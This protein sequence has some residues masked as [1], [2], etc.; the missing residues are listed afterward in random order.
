MPGSSPEQI[1][2]ITKYHTLLSQLSPAIEIKVLGSYAISIP[3]SYITNFEFSVN[4]MQAHIELFDSSFYIIDTFAFVLA[5]L[6]MKGVPVKVK[7]GYVYNSATPTITN[8]RVQAANQAFYMSKEH[9]LVVRAIESKPDEKGSRVTI[10]FIIDTFD[11]VL[12]SIPVNKTFVSGDLVSL[13]ANA[14]NLRNTLIEKWKKGNEEDKKRAATAEA[15]IAK[16][17]SIS[18][19]NRGSEAALQQAL[20]TKFGPEVEIIGNGGKLTFTEIYFRLMKIANEGQNNLGARSVPWNIPLPVFPAEFD[21]SYDYAIFTCDGNNV[22]TNILKLAS[23][24]MS[25]PQT[26]NYNQTGQTLASDVSD[27][28]T[29]IG[30]KRTYHSARIDKPITG[31]NLYS[32]YNQIIQ[33]DRLPPGQTSFCVWQFDEAPYE[34]S[35][36]QEPVAYFKYHAGEPG[37]FN[38]NNLTEVLEFTVELENMQ[39]YFMNTTF[40]SLQGARNRVSGANVDF[41]NV[42][43]VNPETARQSSIT[44]TVNNGQPIVNGTDSAPTTQTNPSEDRNTINRQTTSVTAPTDQS[45]QRRF[46]VFGTINPDRDR[47][48]LKEFDNAI[49]SAAAKDYMKAFKAEMTIIGDPKWDAVSFAYNKSIYFEYINKQ[50]TINPLYT[51]SYIILNVKQVINNSKF[52]TILSLQKVDDVNPREANSENATVNATN[53]VEG[54]DNAS[55]AG[56]PITTAQISLVV[57]K[58]GNTGWRVQSVNAYAGSEYKDSQRVEEILKTGGDVAGK[59]INGANDIVTAVSGTFEDLLRDVKG[60]QAAVVQNSQKIGSSS[61]NVNTKFIIHEIIKLV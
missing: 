10:N 11:P 9:N 20:Q 16:L 41:R 5:R 55:A 4:D 39:S 7:W 44:Q 22:E 43:P 48:N 17:T 60:K 21:N 56:Q 36:Q 40:F 46:D 33:I 59:V 2:E 29:M 26:R 57:S 14:N 37:S 18:Q 8:E 25:K 28:F 31:S 19:T 12:T 34:I 6:S 61:T 49:K 24:M 45:T 15:A 32:N 42:D 35:V 53:A 23:M 52:V 47:D 50:G 13:D 30:G 54:F 27:R 1:S 58:N 3:F 38:K 51:G